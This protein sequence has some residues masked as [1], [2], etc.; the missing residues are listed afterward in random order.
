MVPPYVL[1]GDGRDKLARVGTLALKAH[2]PGSIDREGVIRSRIH[3]EDWPDRDL[4]I[5]A[6]EAETG[7]FTV[8]TATAASTS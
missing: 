3:T 7:Q 8:F 4:R 1:P 2:E 5:T 6:V